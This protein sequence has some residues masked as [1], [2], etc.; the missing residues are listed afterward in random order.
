MSDERRVE[1]VRRSRH[2]GS[3]IALLRRLGPSRQKL[4]RPVFEYPRHYVLLSAREMARQLKKDSATVVRSVRAMGFS[5][6]KE[7]QHYLHELSVASTTPLELMKGVAGLDS[8]LPAYAKE[9]LDRDAKNFQ[10]L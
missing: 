5:G 9:S 6:Y 2:Y 3:P 10:L 1:A 4:M 8:D 7:F